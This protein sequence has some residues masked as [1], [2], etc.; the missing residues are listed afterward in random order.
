MN[1][2]EA[3]RTP[4][5]REFTYYGTYDVAVR[6]DGYDTLK[7]TGVVIAPWWNWVPLDL[8]AAIFP[9][10]DKQK[11]HYGLAPAATQPADND[12]LVARAR[13]LEAELPATQPVNP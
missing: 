11:L 6:K 13:Q 12:A 8:V 5:T 2:I 3:G 4:F 1:D 7:T 9:L 10:H